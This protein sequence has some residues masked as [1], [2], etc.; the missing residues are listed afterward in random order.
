MRAHFNWHST[1]LPPAGTASDPCACPAGFSRC[2]GRCLSHLLTQK[3]TYAAA[4]AA[5]AELGAHL[6]VPRSEAE[7]QCVISASVVQN[8]PMLGVTDIVDEGSFVGDDAR[9]GAVPADAAWWAAGEPN[10][11][12]DEDCVVVGSGMWNDVPCWLAYYPLCQL[13]HCHRPE[14]P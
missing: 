7:N 11:A 3:L 2:A 1:R 13:R 14:C 6:A 8:Q 10:N 12:G 9:C 5:C 4:A